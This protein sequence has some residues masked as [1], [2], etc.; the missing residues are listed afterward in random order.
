MVEMIRAFRDAGLDSPELD[1]RFLIQGLLDVDGAQLLADPLRPLGASALA[2]MEAARRRLAREPVSRILGWRE[3]YGRRFKITPAVLDPRPETET[4]ITLALDIGRERGWETREIT[5]FDI[6]AGSGAIVATLLV[7]WPRAKAYASDVSRAALAVAEDNAEALGVAGRLTLLEGR[8]LAGVTAPLDLIIS[9]P[10]YIPMLEIAG[11]QPDVRNYD[12]VM[13]LDGGLDGL[14]IY[15]E[16]A[17]DIIGLGQS[18]LIVLEIG[19]GQEREVSA[20]FAALGGLNLRTARDLAGKPRAVAL[21]IH[22]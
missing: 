15:R 19:D 16:I 7:E 13:A 14:D 17:K 20:I 10:P 3:F 9:N 22:C 6:G 18:A 12:P 2:I 1:A 5:L 8:G 4:V 21:E 11:L